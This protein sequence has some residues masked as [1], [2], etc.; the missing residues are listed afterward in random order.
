MWTAQNMNICWVMSSVRRQLML[1]LFSCRSNNVR[2]Q[3]QQFRYCTVHSQRDV[4]DGFTLLTDWILLSC[5][6]GAALW[7]FVVVCCFF[8]RF[9]RSKASLKW[10]CYC[11]CSLHCCLL[12]PVCRSLFRLLLLLHT[13][14]FVR[15]FVLIADHSQSVCAYWTHNAIVH[16][17][18][19]AKHCARELRMSIVRIYLWLKIG[20]FPNRLIWFNNLNFATGY[21]NRLELFERL[22]ILRIRHANCVK[23]ALRFVLGPKNTYFDAISI[24]NR[25]AT[26]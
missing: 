12:W 2:R 5:A 4:T 1:V 24:V 9:A 3:N 11:L 26:F 25:H 18:T 20:R 23:C 13:H 22:I 6:C 19:H 15:S 14:S 21:L 8:R 17:R 7:L 10:I 16:T